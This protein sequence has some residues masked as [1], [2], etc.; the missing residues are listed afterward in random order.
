MAAATTTAG[1]GLRLEGVTKSYGATRALVDVSFEVEAEKIHAL[2]GGNGSGKSTLIKVLAGVVAADAGELRLEGEAQDLR[3]H[4]PLR[5]RQLQMHFVHQQNSTF[6]E[7]T[8]AENL[9][10]GRG[11]EKT[12][13]GLV[14]WR[15]VRRRARRILDHFEIDARPDDPLR[16]LGPA[17][18]MMVAI[19][20]ALQDQ[21]EG[22]RST[23]VLDEPTA[24]LPTHEVDLLLAA[25][26]RY[27]RLGC[28]ILYV[29]HRLDEVI[30]VAERSTVLRDGHHVTTTDTSAIDQAELVELIMG[31]PAA[32]FERRRRASQAWKG[33]L[34]VL[35][36][37]ELGRSGRVELEIRP[38]ELLGIAGMMASGRSTLLRQLFGSGPAPTPTVEFC[39][40]ETK[41]AGPREAME[42]GIGLLPEDRPREAMFAT[43]SISE[44][45]SVAA[46]GDHGRF[47]RVSRSRELRTARRL[48]DDF[49]V[50]ASG[51]TAPIAA[52]SGGNQQKVMLARWLQRRPRLL[53]LDE[54]TQGVDVGARAEILDLL[55]EAVDDGMAAVMV[56]S[57]FEELALECDRVLVLRDGQIVADLDGDIEEAQLNAFAYASEAA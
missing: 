8:V 35:K 7:M 57:D 14:R 49:Q 29:T 3:A 32:H 1:G 21:E 48:M 37:G 39:G 30:K 23:L 36:G 54:P 40:E 47:G 15:A 24:S 53:L 5:A 45:L 19:A 18:Q 26:Q 56:S 55:R 9:S 42:L 25:L 34:P 2:L 43:L 52:L 12:V 17:M 46:L 38:G 41:I 22:S 27:A 16:T 10:L 6:P 13:G 20:R 51:A 31:K 33:E 11:F 50:V 28:S 4:T 44:N